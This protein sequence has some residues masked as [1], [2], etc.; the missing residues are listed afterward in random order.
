MSLYGK[1]DAA[2]SAQ[3][4]KQAVADNKATRGSTAYANTTV[5]A[6]VPG[7]AVGLFGINSTIEHAL[8]V[9]GKAH[10]AGPGWN[11]ISWGTGPVATLALNAAGTGYSNTDSVV[12]QA[13]GAVNAS[14]NVVTNG[15]GVIQTVTLNNPGKFFA[16]NSSLTISV[17]A[18][19]GGASAGTGATFNVTLGGRANRKQVET[20]VAQRTMT[21]STSGGT[22]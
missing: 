19:G 17:K 5:G 12:V 15:S 8:R 11:K 16:N 13:S 2:A 14:A 4:S 1:V 6:F 3:K 9:A 10:G 21:G 20:M 7:K 18:S 22:L